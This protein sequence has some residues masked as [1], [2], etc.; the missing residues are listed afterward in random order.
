[1]KKLF[2]FLTVLLSFS[3]VFVFAGN[4]NLEKTTPVRQAFMEKAP[5]TFDAVAYVNAQRE[6]FD[7]LKAEAA[8]IY[9][10]STIHV[11]QEEMDE[12]NNHKCTT[13][14]QRAEAVR[15]G[16]VKPIGV[17]ASFSSL[18]SLTR[19]ADGGF[20]WTY[21]I[22]SPGATAL[23]VHLSNFNLP[24]N[25][26]L[27]IYGINGEAFGPYSDLGPGN[28]GDFWTHT[29]TGP[30]AYLQLRHFGPVSESALPSINFNIADLGHIGPKFLIAFFHDLDRVPEEADKVLE[31]CSYNEACVVD[32]TC[33]SSTA[34]NNAKYAVAHMEWVSG[35]WLYYCTGGLIADTDTQ[36]QIPYFL[37]ANHCI[38]DEEDAAGLEC[39]F[40]YWTSS[41]G[42]TCPSPGTFPRTLGATIKDTSTYGDHTLMQLSQ[43]P[44]AGSYFMGW[45]N[46]PVAN[47]DG[48]Q[49]FRISHP[50]GAPQAY[51]KHEVDTQFGYCSGM[52]IGEFIYSY[53]LE[54]ATEGGSS[55]GPVYNMNGQIV[56]QLYGACGY[57]LEVC[58]AEQNR[59][60]DG[61]F[62]AYYSSVAPWLDPSSPPQG[63]DMHVA[64]IVLSLKQ[65]GPNATAKA[66]VT[67]VDANG[68][69]VAGAT[70]SGTFS[71]DVSGS[72]SAVT[73]STGVA[74]FELKKK[75]SV[76]TFTFCVNNVTLSG[77]TYDSSANVETCDTY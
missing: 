28:A 34:I 6:V 64:S 11:S 7:W 61:A 54:G 9:N 33:Y 77:W 18:K 76:S 46:S 14:S 70:V 15:I 38:S 43:N 12:V 40:Q 25:A 13:C 21:A 59:T 50:S 10:S 24:E 47:S 35:P 20:V 29:I 36:T 57:T 67:I 41:C 63:D 8:P 4:G 48:T 72:G 31:H 42:G 74:T 58:D 71:G 5:G 51:S 19:T 1:M 60:V 2:V 62:A 75:A 44:P 68:S 27:Y 49:L 39:F 17:N 30:I 65:A 69:P 26:V 52:P 55:G 16:L 23:R 32:A 53:D 37:T 45:T 66:L 3:L 73:T 22:E 56:G